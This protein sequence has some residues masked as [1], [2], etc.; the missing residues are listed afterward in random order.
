MPLEKASTW[1]IRSGK[2]AA[3]EFAH[4]EPKYQGRIRSAIA[5]L[6][7]DPVS[8]KALQGQLAGV[9]SLRVWPYW[10][11]YWINQSEIVVEVL[12]IRHR[13]GAYK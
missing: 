9:R 3:K 8:G 5:R 4:I 11:L 1:I 13:Q 7:T 6:A 10:V 12:E 2:Q